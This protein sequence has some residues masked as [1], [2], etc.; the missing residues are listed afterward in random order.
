MAREGITLEV[1]SETKDKNTGKAYKRMVVEK[2]QETKHRKASRTYHEKLSRM[3]NWARKKVETSKK[4]KKGKK[5]N[6]SDKK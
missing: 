2:W 6:A 3:G 1:I 4:K 5:K